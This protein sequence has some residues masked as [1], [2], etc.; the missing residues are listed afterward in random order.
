MRTSQ[1]Q[2]REEMHAMYIRM[3]DPALIE[4]RKRKEQ[5]A[6][7]ASKRKKRYGL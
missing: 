6:Q 4:Q 3:T 5:R 7:R 2:L 1:D